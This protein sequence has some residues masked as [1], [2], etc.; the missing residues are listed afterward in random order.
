[1]TGVNT[2]GVPAS[3]TRPALTRLDRPVLVGNLVSGALWLLLLASLGGW[4]LSLVGAAYVAVGSV[5]LAAVYGRDSLTVRQEALAW[6]TPW[7]VAVALWTWVGAG[8]EG[9]TSI[10]LLTLWFGLVFG[11][12]SYLAWQLLAL[13]VRQ[14]MAWKART[15]PSRR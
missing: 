7:L 11:T 3:A 15:A 4:V 14:L 8:I 13:A 5:F 2:T 12:G 1:M 9:G 10:G 6:V